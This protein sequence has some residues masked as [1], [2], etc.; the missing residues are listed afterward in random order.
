MVRAEDDE[1]PPLEAEVAQGVEEPP[2]LRVRE[3][4]LAVVERHDPGDVRLAE[5]HALRANRLQPGDGGRDGGGARR[6]EGVVSGR[7]RVVGV[8]ADEVEPQQERPVPHLLEVA[9]GRRHRRLVLRGLVGPPRA[10]DAGEAGVLGARH[11]GEERGGAVAPGVEEVRQRHEPPAGAPA[12]P[13]HTVRA[14]VEGGVEG[15]QGGPGGA[16]DRFGVPEEQ[17]PPGEAVDARARGPRVPVGPE[18]IGTEGVHRHHHDVR[19]TGRT[20]AID[21]R[22]F[23][24]RRAGEGPAL[25]C[26]I[27]RDR[28]EQLGRV[29]LDRHEVRGQG[30]PRRPR[31]HH[32]L[33]EDPRRPALGPGLD[34]RPA[35]PTAERLRPGPVER[36]LR[37]DAG[38]G[39][40][41]GAPRQ[42]RREVGDDR[43]QPG[44]VAVAQHLRPAVRRLQTENRGTGDRPGRAEPQEPGGGPREDDGG[45]GEN[46]GALPHGQ[47]LMMPWRLEDHNP[48]R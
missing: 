14:G 43:A 11:V 15:G 18:V 39:G 42:R 2:H 25:G 41:R 29:S 34:T 5:H 48:P 32:P 33:H 16:L 1:G 46:E 4:H 8:G 28:Q 23:P 12:V 6:P 20:G 37:G 38:P 9:H 17:A 47:L 22:H 24:P 27:A 35:R 21:G 13:D 7:G 3:R 26:R 10:D 44:R 36:E 19:V 45:D 30:L 40:H 31:H